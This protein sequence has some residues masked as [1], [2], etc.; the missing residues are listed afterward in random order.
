MRNLF[1]KIKN[2]F[3]RS[4]GK[5]IDYNTLV[6]MVKENKG[7]KIIDV[8]TKDEYYNRHIDNA[9]NIPLQNLNERINTVVRNRNDI[10]IVY[11]EYGGRSEKA[12]MKLEKMGYINV[13][14]LEN[15]IAGI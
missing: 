3:V 14:N 1:Y 4:Y 7:V 6:R 5:N 13:Y 12:C 15:G 8:R 10:I 2:R 11:C 9:I